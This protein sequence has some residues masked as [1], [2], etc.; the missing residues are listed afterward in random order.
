LLDVA[1]P[2]ATTF[3]RAFDLTRDPREALEVL[4]ELG[5]ARVLSSGQATTALE[6]ASLLRG[7]VEQSAGRI[8]VMPGA[9]ITAGNVARL[10][11]E[12]GA[13]ELHA[14]AS[15]PIEP[16]E[17]SAKSPCERWD[18]VSPSRWT[19]AARVRSLRAAIDAVTGLP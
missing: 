2:I 12:T 16:I 6:G 13:G 4:S 3:H 18:F 9:G 11:T 10:L 17:P 1:G 14:S 15:E 5:V 7:L 8:A 19:T